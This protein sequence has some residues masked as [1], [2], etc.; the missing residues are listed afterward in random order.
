M[1]QPYSAPIELSDDPLDRYRQ[2]VER[3]LGDK[4]VL[5]EERDYERFFDH[6]ITCF[7]RGLDAAECAHAW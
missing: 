6:V 7:E 1:P 3:R 2:A 5:L 4:L